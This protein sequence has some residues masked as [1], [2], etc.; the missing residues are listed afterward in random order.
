MAHIN[1]QLKEIYD[2]HWSGL[3]SAADSLMTAPIK[4]ANPL[5]IRINEEAYE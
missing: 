2:Y 5:L 3:V 1:S 4:P